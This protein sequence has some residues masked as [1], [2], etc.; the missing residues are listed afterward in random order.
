MSSTSEISRYESPFEITQHDNGARCGSDN[1][2]SAP[3]DA[4]ALLDLRGVG[5][6]RRP[7]V[8]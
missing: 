1:V 7:V 8:A 5:V 2:A 4:L 3:V 6:G